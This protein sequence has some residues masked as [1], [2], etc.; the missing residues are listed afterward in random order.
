MK[1]LGKLM[2]VLECF[3][4]NDRALT[5]AE[6]CKRTAYPRSTTHRLMASLRDVGLL[7]QDKERDSYR[8]GLKLFELGNIALSNM[9]IH[10]EAFPH[11]EALQRLTGYTTT[12]A[13]F[14][15]YRASSYSAD[16]RNGRSCAISNSCR[17]RPRPLY[18]CGKGSPGIPISGGG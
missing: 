2:A 4:I 6:I 18:Q 7:E 12:V 14:D 11:V 1:S 16:E 10:R 5:L 3:S 17:A 9:E 13:I 8:L 15:G